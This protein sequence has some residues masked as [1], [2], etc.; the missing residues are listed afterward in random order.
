MLK[1][2]P[3]GAF[4]VMRKPLSRLLALSII[5][6]ALLS[7]S[8][9]LHSPTGEWLEMAGFTL[10]I[11]AAL[12]RIWSAIYISGRKNETLCTEGPYELTRNPLYFFSFIGVI[13]F[14]LALQSWLAAG[15]LAVLFFGYYQLVIANEESRLATLF[16]APYSRYVETTP[17]FFPRLAK[18]KRIA[19]YVV[20]PAILERSLSEVFW[21]LF[22]I[23]LLE[24]LEAVH[25]SGHWILF[26]LPW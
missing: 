7:G 21:F 25:Q 23:I 14:G 15:V 9:L 4:E 12:G 5:S 2:L 24:L 8:A 17:R 13:G 6:V 1:T 16:G 11:T 22:A 10:L 3:H 26:E 18:P 19:Q 20:S